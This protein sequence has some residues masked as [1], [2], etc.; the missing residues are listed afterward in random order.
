V[1]LAKNMNGWSSEQGEKRCE[2]HPKT[3]LH[4]DSALNKLLFSRE[5]GEKQRGADELSREKK[6]WIAP[7]RGLVVFSSRLNKRVKTGGKSL[8][9]LRKSK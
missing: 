9:R 6:S 4:G 8:R 3:A 5:G 1:L 7:R 2:E